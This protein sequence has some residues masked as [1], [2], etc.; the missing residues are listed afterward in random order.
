MSSRDWLFRVAASRQ[1]RI[2]SWIA[3]AAL[4]LIAGKKLTK[5]FPHRFLARRGRN[6]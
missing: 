3:K 2:V 5:N 4:L 6:V 1:L